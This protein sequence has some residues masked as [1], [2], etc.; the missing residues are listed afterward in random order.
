M[1]QLPHYKKLDAP[2]P[3]FLAMDYDMLRRAFD[4]I[5]QEIGFNRWKELARELPQEAS[6][7]L[8]I[9]FHFWLMGQY[10]EVDIPDNATPE[11]AA[12]LAL[13][14][15]TKIS[16]A[17]LRK[18]VAKGHKVFPEKN[19]QII[20]QRWEKAYIDPKLNIIRVPL[21]NEKEEI[22]LDLSEVDEDGNTVKDLF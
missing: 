4:H 19:L 16:P 17:R 9:P 2:H 11:Q 5:K 10:T 21:E 1:K 6:T 7:S 20:Q 15:E 3:A 13:S 8:S 18:L 14:A 22:V 12:Y